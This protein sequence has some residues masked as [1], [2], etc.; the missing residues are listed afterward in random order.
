M[1]R[2]GFTLIE[3]LAVIVIL[4]ILAVLVTPMVNDTIN[5]AKQKTFKNTVEGM[6]RSIQLD[7]SDKDYSAAKYTVA[8]GVILDESGNKVHTSGGSN[9]NGTIHIDEDGNITLSVHD[10]KWCATKTAS[11]NKIEMSKFEEGA[12]GVIET[13]NGAQTIIDLGITE[14]GEGLYENP[15]QNGGGYVFKG[16]QNKNNLI[17]DDKCW[18]VIG[19]DGNN[20]VKLILNRKAQDGKCRSDNATYDLSVAWNGTQSSYTNYWFDSK[21]TMRTT[22]ES[23]ANGQSFNGFSIENLDKVANHTWNVGAVNASIQLGAPTNISSILEQEK[24]GGISS[25]PA[26][27]PYQWQNKVGLL[28]VSDAMNGSTMSVCQ[29][30]SWGDYLSAYIPYFCV[31]QNSI[32][33]SGWTLNAYEYDKRAVVFSSELTKHTYQEEYFVPV[34]YLNSNVKI[35]GSGTVNDPFVAT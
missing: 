2:K 24:N 28:N 16:G 15:K 26:A 22:L 20:Q 17:F 31:E 3:L 11:N 23:L 32:S 35:T 9:E 12:C 10:N 33:P 19:I 29:S 14:S 8:D 4:A 7:A 30:E 21:T 1:N 18:Y 27:G 6:I 5:N 13:T 34:I 25:W